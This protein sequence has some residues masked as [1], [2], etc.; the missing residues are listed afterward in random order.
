MTKG[1]C[2]RTP[3]AWGRKSRLIRGAQQADELE[4]QLHDQQ[5]AA[6]A[7]EAAAVATA[8]AAAQKTEAETH[9][10][11]EHENRVNAL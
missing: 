2:W 5:A 3:G 6:E 10:W 7:A 8:I 4:K 11:T 9:Q 1:V